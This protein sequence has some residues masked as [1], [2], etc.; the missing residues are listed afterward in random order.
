MSG[1]VGTVET[2]ERQAQLDAI[3]QSGWGVRFRFL[4]PRNLAFW[5]YVLGVG[6][7]IV[8]MVK[9]FGQATG[10]YGTALAGGVVLFAIYLVPWL[11]FLHHQNRFTSQP[12]R[13]LIAAFV[14]GATAATF[15]IAITANGALLEI[16]AKIGGTAFAQQWA[17]G[18]TA[19]INEEWGKA[20]GL[21]LLLC[22]ARRIVRS[23]YDGFIIGAYIG[24]GFQVSEDVLYV[25]N[26]AMASFGSD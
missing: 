5:V 19:P 10:F 4:Q 24:L 9:F 8:G 2:D 1:G 6:A 15:W 25:V 14:W 3:E 18:L 13:L 20:V 21:V 11:L 12:P 22:L 23:P 16:W 7:G 17:A 26:G